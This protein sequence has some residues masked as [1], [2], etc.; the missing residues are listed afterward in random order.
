MRRLD[1]AMAEAHLFYL[2]ARKQLDSVQRRQKCMHDIELNEKANSE[3]DL[4]YRLNE[5][6]PV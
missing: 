2:F 5:A 3:G 1:K 4:V 6:T